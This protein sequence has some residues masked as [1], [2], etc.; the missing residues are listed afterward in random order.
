MD[1]ILLTS[2]NPGQL[3]HTTGVVTQTTGQAMHV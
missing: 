1:L 3:V 2:N